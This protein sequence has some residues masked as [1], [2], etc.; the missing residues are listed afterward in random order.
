MIIQ[1][2][3]FGIVLSSRPAGR[4]AY[5]AARSYLLGTANDSVKIDCSGVKVLTPSW[6][7]EFFTPLKKLLGKRMT[8]LPSDNHS[9]VSSLKTIKA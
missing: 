8:I 7:D 2:K 4:D 1:L 5:L 3:K 9:V 6:A